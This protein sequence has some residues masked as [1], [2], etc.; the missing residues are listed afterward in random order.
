LPLQ[1]WFIRCF[2]LTNE[3]VKRA[4]AIDSRV[5][6]L[7]DGAVVYFEDGHKTPCGPR[8]R[9]GGEAH[10]FGGHAAEKFAIPEGVEITKV[11]VGRS[12]EINGLRFHKSDGTHGGYLYDDS[13]KISLSKSNRSSVL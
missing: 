7:L 10:H 5:G 2:I 13:T 6:C 1:T 9:K 4:T 12:G 8:W 11:E 3:V